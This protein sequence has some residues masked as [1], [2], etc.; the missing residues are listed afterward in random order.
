MTKREMIQ[1]IQKREA[2]LFLDLKRAQR[3]FEDDSVQVRTRRHAWAAVSRLMIDMGIQS[4]FDML[5]WKEAV[6]HK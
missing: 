4:D 1:T 5:E 2:D 3:I 6:E